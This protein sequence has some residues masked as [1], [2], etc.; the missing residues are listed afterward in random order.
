MST[1]ILGG[2]ISGLSAAWFLRRKDPRLKI[3]LLEKS[4][5]L[6]GF[7]QTERKDGFLFEK[8]PRTFQSS[9]SPALLS[10][11]SDLGLEPELIF[12]AP[13]KRYLCHRG[14]LRSLGSFIPSLLPALLREPFIPRSGKEDESIYDFAARRFSPK[15]AETFFDPLTLGVYGGD[16]RKLSIRSCFSQFYRY[17][18]EKGSILRGMLASSS[19]KPKKVHGLFTLKNGMQQLIETLAKKLDIEI[20]CNCEVESIQKNEVHAR[21]KSWSADQIFSALPASVI[22]RLLGTPFTMN[23]MWVVNLVFEGPCLAKKGFGYLVPTQEKQSLLGMI[24]D[25][26]V[27]PQQN[28]QN[29][30][31]LTAMVREEEKDPLNRTLNAARQ[32]LDIQKE[33]LKCSISHAIQAIPQFEVGYWQKI[34][35]FEKQAYPL[36]LLGNY[37]EGVSVEDCIQRSKRMILSPQPVV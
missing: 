14:K 30:T 2:G 13:T 26:S 3:T 23:S 35:L 11:I 34:S 18:K 7:I 32:H 33:P 20:V 5:R 10:L 36:I 6:G 37:I 25:S 29:E 15:I 31:R 4:H 8:G 1:L 17:E 22:G 27:F 24:W 12:S 21:G 19:P 9:R 28:L 16:I